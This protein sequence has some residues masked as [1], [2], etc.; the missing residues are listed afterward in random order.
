MS[1]TGKD[2]HNDTWAEY[3]RLVLAELERLNNAVSKLAQVDLDHEKDLHNHKAELIERMQKLKDVIEIANRESIA[4]VKKELIEQGKGDINELRTQT[5]DL[6]ESYHKVSSEV[7]IIKAK[8]AFF[9]F[10]AG[11]I[12]AIVSLIIKI[13]WGT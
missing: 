7:K 4:D 3:R 12:I 2:M 6:Q 10:L 1:N 8:S 9:G 11:M 5:K 13:M